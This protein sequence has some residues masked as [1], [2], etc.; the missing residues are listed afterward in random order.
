MASAPICNAL[1]DILINFKA[2]ERDMREPIH[3]SFEAAVSTGPVCTE[4]EQARIHAAQ[5][6]QQN[7]KPG[8]D[9]VEQQRAHDYFL[10]SA[11]NKFG[12]SPG[13]IRRRATIWSMTVPLNFP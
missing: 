13:A 11:R 4:V 2:N 9:E 10:L 7:P 5:E 1:Y 12:F 6:T 3:S 8:R